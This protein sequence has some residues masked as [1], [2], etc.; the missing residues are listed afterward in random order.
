[1]PRWNGFGVTFDH[2]RAHCSRT[3]H[4]IVSITLHRERRQ[5]GWIHVKVLSIPLSSRALS[6]PIDWPCSDQHH[7]K[8]DKQRYGL[9][10]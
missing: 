1:M 7:R 10:A 4:L 8:A 3:R 2:E 6:F 5:R 9:D